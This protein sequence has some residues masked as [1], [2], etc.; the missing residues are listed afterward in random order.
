MSHPADA[1]MPQRGCDVP[2]A[3]AERFRVCLGMASRVG[4]TVAMLDEAAR[5]AARRRDVVAGIVETHDRPADIVEAITGTRLH[6][7]AGAS[8]LRRLARLAGEAGID[9]HIIARSTISAAAGP[10]SGQAW[11]EGSAVPTY[12]PDQGESAATV[13][14]QDGWWNKCR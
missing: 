4:K 8:T 13:R 11:P 9:V 3:A 5:R 7:L 2:V 6:L 10:H 14:W 12:A 1:S